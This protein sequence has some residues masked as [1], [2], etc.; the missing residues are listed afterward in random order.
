VTNKNKNKKKIDNT[1]CVI[2]GEKID[3][4][5]NPGR[6][7]DTCSR[8]EVD[9]KS[10]KSICE[11]IKAQRYQKKYRKKL[12]E[13]KKKGYVETY[14]Q[15]SFAE[16]EIPIIEVEKVK[17]NCLRCETEFMA[18]GRFNRICERCTRL[19]TQHSY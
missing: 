6:I 1:K 3:I 9:G 4:K 17:R 7:R 2:C 11:L 8:I 15:S 18:E 19:N 13:R 10:V 12:E 5:E 16:I 14:V